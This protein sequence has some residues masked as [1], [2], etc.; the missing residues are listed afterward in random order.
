MYN[1]QFGFNPYYQPP[2]FN[3]T[4]QQPI[5]QPIQPQPVM[6]NNL[7]SRQTLNGKMVDSVDVV[8]ATEA[9]LDGSTAYYPLTDNSAIIT[10]RLLTDGTS[11]MTIYKPVEEKETPKIEYAT[12]EDLKKSI[13]DLDLSDI[14]DLKEEIREL[15]QEFKDFKK[16]NKKKD[17]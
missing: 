4:M 10:K 2:R 12:M 11:K 6:N 1:N 16:N 5:E 13:N 17:E 15:K 14:D 7:M 9:S 8:K 3:N